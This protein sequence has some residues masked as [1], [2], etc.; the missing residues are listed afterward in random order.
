MMHMYHMIKKEHPTTA[1]H[2]TFFDGGNGGGGGSGSGSGK[3]EEDPTSHK[4]KS[5]EDSSTK[6]EK[7]GEAE[8]DKKGEEDKGKGKQVISSDEDYYY[9]GEKDDF[10]AFNDALNEDYQEELPRIN[11]SEPEASFDEWEEE[12]PSNAQ[13][14]EQFK[15]YQLNLQRKEDKLEKIYQLISKK[16]E[17]L[18]L[19]K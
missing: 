18:K 12:V 3:G 15:K 4:S 14:D 9:Q 11:E 13:F 17:L 5:V 2:M 7:K 1:E 19:R 16:A 8:K 6:E 10:D